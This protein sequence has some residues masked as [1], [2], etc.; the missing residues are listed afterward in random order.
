MVSALYTRK[1]SIYKK[2]NIDCWDVQRDARN[3][4]GPGPIICHP[5]CR[6]WGQCRWLAKP[7]EGEKELSIIAVNQVRKFGGILEHPSRSSLWPYMNL[8]LPNQVPDR[9]GGFSISIDQSWWG[10]LVRKPTLLYIVGTTL[11][12]MPAC[13]IRFDA[14]T[15]T[16]FVSQRMAKRKKLGQRQKKVLSKAGRETTPIEFAKWLIEVAELC[17]DI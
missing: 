17:K 1:N 4:T 12:K 3:Y 2:L 9:Y 7:K 16:I 11:K 15:H 6:S 10:H 8:P 5:P 14:I 13:P